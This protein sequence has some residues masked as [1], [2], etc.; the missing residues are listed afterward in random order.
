MSITNAIATGTAQGAAVA[1]TYQVGAI[2]PSLLS[3]SGSGF[4]T[5]FPKKEFFP[6]FFLPLLCLLHNISASGFKQKTSL[7]SY[8]CWRRKA[9]LHTACVMWKTTLKDA[10]LFINTVKL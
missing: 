2:C 10:F 9:Q 6:K 5:F 7:A 4:A 8:G 3:L 1:H